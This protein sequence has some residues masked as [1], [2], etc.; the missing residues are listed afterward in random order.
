MSEEVTFTVMKSLTTPGLGDASKIVFRED[1]E[2]MPMGFW[3]KVGSGQH[4][5]TSRTV[6]STGDAGITTLGQAQGIVAQVKEYLEN[7]T[8]RYVVYG[9]GGLLLLGVLVKLARRRKT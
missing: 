7:P 2:Q 6:G 1:G 9:V 3:I 8:I 5:G 4:G